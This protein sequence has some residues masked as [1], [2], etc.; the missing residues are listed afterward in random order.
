MSWKVE[1][2]RGDAARGA[3]S[4]LNVPR[5]KRSGAASLPVASRLE[6]LR[7][8]IAWLFVGVF[9]ATLLSQRA[10]ALDIGSTFPSFAGYRFEGTPP[11]LA[12]KV[13]VVD[14]W[15]SWCAPCKASFPVLS[16]VQNEFGSK[17]VVVL[18]ISVDEKSGPYEQFR[19]RLNPSF[20]TIR[21]GEHRLTSDVSVPTMPTSFVL[22]RTGRVRFVHAGFHDE[23]PARL[24]DELKQLL[25][26]K[27]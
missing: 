8:G 6:K 13:V 10:S 23:T 9:A 24:R 11:D 17:G 18:G 16:S 2:E 25:E 7:T 12:G 22:D 27:P 20:P 1:Y 14:F 4:G 21:D 26:E 19:K 3:G 15:A 5:A